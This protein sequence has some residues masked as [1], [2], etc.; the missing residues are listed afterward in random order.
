MNIDVQ[1]YRENGYLLVKKLFD[2]QMV[3]RIREELSVLAAQADEMEPGSFIYEDNHEEIRKQS[4]NPL[5]WI[6][7]IDL[8]AMRHSRFLMGLFRDGRSKVARI[9][10]RLVDDEALRLI[11]LS[12]FAKPPRG[13]AEIPWHQ[14]QGL[15]DLWMPNAISG[16]VALSQTTDENGVLQVVPGSHLQ[17]MVRH[18]VLPGKIHESI[19]VSAFPDM[20]AVKVYMEPGDAVFFGGL[21]WHF[22]E[23]NR[24]DGR[25]LGMPVVYVGENQLR[26]S[27]SCSEWVESK[28][29]M[30]E[31]MAPLPMTEE[32]RKFYRDRSKLCVQGEGR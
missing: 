12:T 7:K 24:S 11:F 16:W 22:S 30:P 21:T 6:R 27:L 25:R 10:A 28:L 18:Q 8:K 14:D 1:F 4:G 20:E 15:W 9:C 17:G 29:G 31:N 26:D 23:P 3:G 5:D 19:D 13:G 2:E 32:R